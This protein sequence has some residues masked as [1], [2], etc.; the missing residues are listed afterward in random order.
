MSVSSY[1][2][3]DAVQSVYNIQNTFLKKILDFK[4]DQADSIYES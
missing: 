3:K 4:T 1:R 2:I